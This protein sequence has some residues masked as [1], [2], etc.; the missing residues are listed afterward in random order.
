VS[1]E[2]QI[3]ASDKDNPKILFTV[4]ALRSEGKKRA[5]KIQMLS[6]HGC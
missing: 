1:P 2:G 4:V 5:K 3:R 6:P